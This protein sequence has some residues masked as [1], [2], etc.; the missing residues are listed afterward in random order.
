MNGM[1]KFNEYFKA[2]HGEKR[3]LAE[4]LNLAPSTVTQ[5][6]SIPVEY[7]PEISAWTGIPREELVPDAFREARKLISEETAG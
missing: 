7:L 6:K 2:H 1:E 3:R 5:W 4:S